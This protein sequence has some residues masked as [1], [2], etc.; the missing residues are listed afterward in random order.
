MLD[1]YAASFRVATRT[2]ES[3]LREMPP[4]RGQRRR[5]WFPS[6]PSR[7]IRESDL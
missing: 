3:Q 4:K 1:I 5:R 6:R 2:E 7:T